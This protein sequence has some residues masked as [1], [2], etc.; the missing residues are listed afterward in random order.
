[1][2]QFNEFL[3]SPS[4]QS[5][6]LS[7]RRNQIGFQSLFHKQFPDPLTPR[8]CSSLHPNP[9][10]PLPSPPSPPQDRNLAHML[11]RLGYPKYQVLSLRVNKWVKMERQMFLQLTCML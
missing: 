8:K 5:R 6:I 1:M 7:P 11:S 3:T 9:P 2:L 10:P 4:E